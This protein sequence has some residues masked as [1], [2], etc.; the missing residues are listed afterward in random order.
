MVF[1][2]FI[3]ASQVDANKCHGNSLILTRNFRFTEKSHIQRVVFRKKQ[4]NDPTNLKTSEDYQKF[5]S[6]PKD[7]LT[8]KIFDVVFY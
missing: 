6:V 4:N 8:F 2:C 1:F 5:I 3:F 7:S